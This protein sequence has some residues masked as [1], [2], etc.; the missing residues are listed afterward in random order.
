MWCLPWQLFTW[1]GVRFWLLHDD[2]VEAADGDSD[3][4]EEEEEDLLL[5]LPADEA[6][7]QKAVAA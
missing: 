2:A 5:L 3:N 6:P 4:E 1:N 7:P